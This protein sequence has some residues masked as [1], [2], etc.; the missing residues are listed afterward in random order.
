MGAG[1]SGAGGLGGGFLVFGFFLVFGAG[2]FTRG[3][4]AV[5]LGAGWGGIADDRRRGN[6]RT[7]LTGTPS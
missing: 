5:G 2:G 7:R 6:G 3:L 1:G 4:F